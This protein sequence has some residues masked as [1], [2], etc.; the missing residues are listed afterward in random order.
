MIIT[1]NSM[2]QV[3]VMISIGE[4]ALHEIVQVMTCLLSRM[5]FVEILIIMRLLI[6]LRKYNLTSY[7][8]QLAL[9]LYNINI[10][11]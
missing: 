2:Y 3:I 7:F 11:A 6:I 5:R 1:V 4:T 9:Y 10:H 8:R